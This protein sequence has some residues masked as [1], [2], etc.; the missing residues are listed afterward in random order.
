MQCRAELLCNFIEVGG[1]A[2]CHEDVDFLM[3]ITTLDTR[4]V[5]TQKCN[6][7]CLDTTQGEH[8]DDMQNSRSRRCQILIRTA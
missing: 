4:L 6:Q 5:L 1:P 3:V 8:S 2:A 7:P